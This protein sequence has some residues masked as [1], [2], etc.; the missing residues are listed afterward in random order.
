MCTFE[1]T[2]RYTS[3]LIRSLRTTARVSRAFF[4][5]SLLEVRLSAQRFNQRYA[6]R[7]LLT[8]QSKHGAASAVFRGLRCGHVQETYGTDFV[9]IQR[10]RQRLLRGL[11]RLSLNHQFVCKYSQ[12]RQVVLDFLEN[13]VTR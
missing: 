6:R 4:C 3:G 12:R 2:P 7:K 13:V 11:Y 1:T 8:A 5:K 9:L 10:D